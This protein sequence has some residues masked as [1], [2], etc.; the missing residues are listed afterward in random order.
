MGQKDILPAEQDAVKAC[1]FQASDG[2]FAVSYKEDV[3]IKDGSQLLQIRLHTAQD[4][5]V[6]KTTVC[7]TSLKWSG[8]DEKNNQEIEHHVPAR[9]TI[10]AAQEAAGDVNGDGKIDLADARMAMQYYNG[11]QDL[12]EKQQKSADVNGDGKVSLTDVKL[13]MQYYNGEIDGF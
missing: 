11:T 6:G 5:T 9:I 8:S 12:D 2:T 13:L 7:V 1:S 3:K 4:A 10:H